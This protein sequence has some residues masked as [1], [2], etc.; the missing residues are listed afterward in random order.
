MCV[1]GVM[2]ELG[3]IKGGNERVLQR[4]SEKWKYIHI[5]SL[6]I[7]QLHVIFVFMTQG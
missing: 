2:R 3:I 4:A 7:S 1:G 6:T 5:K